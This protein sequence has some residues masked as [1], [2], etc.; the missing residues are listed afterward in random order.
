METIF[1]KIDAAGIRF[2][3]DEE[4]FVPQVY[5]DKKYKSIGFG[6]VVRKCEAYLLK[7]K[8]TWDQ[9]TWLLKKDLL[10]S[11]T[12]LR[13]VIK[14]KLSQA[15][16]NCLCSLHIN[17]GITRIMNSDLVDLINAGRHQEAAT[18]IRGMNKGYPELNGRRNREADLYLK[19]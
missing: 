12:E 9:A 16:W 3:Q 15:R 18:V 17:V 11:E 8:L 19:G 7:A 6:H 1:N 10:V 4:K 13:K 5:P 14:V 2:I